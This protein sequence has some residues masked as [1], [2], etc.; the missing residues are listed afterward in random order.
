MIDCRWPPAAPWPAASHGPAQRNLLLRIGIA[1]FIEPL[2]TP[3]G[4]NK[5]AH[6]RRVVATWGSAW[7]R[8]RAGQNHTPFAS[9]GVLRA[10]VV[11]AASPPRSRGTRVAP[12]PAA[13]DGGYEEWPYLDEEVLVAR[14]SRKV[15]MTCHW[16]R[17]H[18]G[19]NGIPVLTC[20]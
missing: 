20:H 2:H 8:A 10:G 6:H 19:V 17:H 7:G 3:V 16:F 18:S 4:A 13:D 12:S 1:F 5:A 9:T 15:C 11:V 14:R